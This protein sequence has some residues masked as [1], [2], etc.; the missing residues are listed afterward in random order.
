MHPVMRPFFS[1]FRPGP[2]RPPH[3]M[4][5]PFFSPFRPGPLRPPLEIDYFAFGD[6]RHAQAS[7]TCSEVKH[8]FGD[9]RHAQVSDTSSEVT[10]REAVID[11]QSESTS[12]AHIQNVDMP[13]ASRTCGTL[14]KE[15]STN[16]LR[17]KI[18][19]SHENIKDLFLDKD[20]TIKTYKPKHKIQSS[21]SSIYNL[22][23]KR[24]K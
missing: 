3:P 12:S 10:F 24:K 13:P 8:A 2:L 17:V 19:I 14:G 4:M 1:P 23:K 21:T 11:S 16:K 18:D 15:N 7:H 9:F 6:F 20:N 22:R 5:R